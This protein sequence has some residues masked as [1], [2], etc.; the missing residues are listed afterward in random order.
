MRAPYGACRYCGQEFMSK[1]SLR[2]HE[3]KSCHERPAEKEPEPSPKP[4]RA[5]FRA[6]HVVG[7]VTLWTRDSDERF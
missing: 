3:T 6:R 2:V 1:Q 4:K 5:T 7:G